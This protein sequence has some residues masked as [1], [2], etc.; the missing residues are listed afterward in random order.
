LNGNGEGGEEESEALRNARKAKCRFSNTGD[1][2]SCESDFGGILVMDVA[3]T[4]ERNAV[5]E[6]AGWLA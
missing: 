2:D 5:V 1:V 4:R 6:T 3:T